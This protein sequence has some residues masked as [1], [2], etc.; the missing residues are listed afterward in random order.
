MIRLLGFIDDFLGGIFHRIGLSTAVSTEQLALFRIFFGGLLLCYFLPSWSWLNDVPPGF[1]DP[2]FLSFAYLTDDYLPD[3]VYIFSDVLVVIILLLITLGIHTR[4]CLLFMFVIS[5]ILY[6]YTFSFGKV[7]HYTNL[8]LFTYPVLAFTNS[9]TKF[10]LL[11]DRALNKRTQEVALTVL[12]IVIVFGYLSA[13]LAKFLNWIDFDPDSSGF[14]YWLYYSYFNSGNQYL[15]SPYLFQLPTYLFEPLD[16]LAALFEVSGFF[17]L[18]KGRKYWIFYLTLA[19]AFH[20]ANLLTLNLSFALNVLCFG[21]FIIS[22][23]LERLYSK[24]QTIFLKYKTSLII[25]A[26]LIALIKIVQILT[27]LPVYNYHNYAPLVHFELS[28]DILLWV[29]TIICGIYLLKSR[30]IKQQTTSS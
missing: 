8:F 6:S 13:G 25:A 5:A 26:V 1:F 15:L 10:A 2:Q 3:A 17:F 20:L 19:S 16:Y 12:G 9:G 14:L 23:I 18:L 30:K 4:K 29:F 22:P 27:A 11:K 7:D 28:T 24:R 21:I